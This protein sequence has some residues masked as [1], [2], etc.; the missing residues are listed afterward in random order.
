M[1]VR[2]MS[3]AECDALLERVRLGRLACSMD[4]KPYV[5]PFHFA[6]ADGRLYA[7]SLPGKKI[8][9]MRSNPQVCVLIEEPG[10][11]RDWKSVVVDGFFEELEDRIGSKHLRERAWSLLSKHA[12][13]W[14]PGAQKPATG[15]EGPRHGPV[16]FS[17]HIEQLS[18]REARDTKMR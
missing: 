17:I 11:D 7:F 8:D 18:G 3:A 10:T 12:E 2:T 5:V 4:G 14:E 13:W 16:F 15:S 1:H 6:Y 9:I